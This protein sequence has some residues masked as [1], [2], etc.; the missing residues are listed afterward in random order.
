[1]LIPRTENVV[2]E[3]AQRE[4]LILTP[5]A[6]RPIVAPLHDVMLK[7]FPHPLIIKLLE[8]FASRDVTSDKIARVAQRQ[9]SLTQIVHKKL[10]SLSPREQLPS[11]EATIVLLGMEQSRNLFMEELAGFQLNYAKNAE[12]DC[13]PGDGASTAWVFAAGL[14]YDFLAQVLTDKDLLPQQFAHAIKLAK[15]SQKLAAASGERNLIGLITA[16]ALL[17]NIGK[18]YLAAADPKYLAFLKSA[19]SSQ[20]PRSVR[21]GM[22]QKTWK[23]DH[24]VVGAIACEAFC[25][26]HPVGLAVQFHHFP[27]LAQPRDASA[28]RMA[29]ILALATRMQQSPKRITDLA[30]PVV[31]TWFGAELA[32]TSLQRK[33]VIEGSTAL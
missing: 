3:D 25:F 5:T 13:P 16:A 19:S 24:T 20:M 30:D 4:K 14:I 22:E 26:P 31:E 8:A 23:I 10:M 9:G 11:L 18:L 7:A 21:L 1:M 33:I 15:L 28:F 2:A 29:Q 12:R 27:R 17:S 32:G 6:D